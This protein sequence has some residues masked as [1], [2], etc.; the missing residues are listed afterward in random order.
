MAVVN[1]TDT[2]L[3]IASS[4]YKLFNGSYHY[5]KDCISLNK[6]DV[7]SGNTRVEYGKLKELGKVQ[8]VL[9]SG[10]YHGVRHSWLYVHLNNKTVASYTLPSKL[11]NYQLNKI[12]QY[13]NDNM[14]G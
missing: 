4:R 1:L 3:M 7:Q 11:T 13:I 14:L 6:Y 5:S 2:T 12:Q 8:L 10:I 9:D